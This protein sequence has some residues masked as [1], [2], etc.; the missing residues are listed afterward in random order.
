MC[1]KCGQLWHSGKCDAN[2]DSDFYGWAA[3]NGNVGNCPKCKAR[4][5]KISGCNHMTCGSC[6]YGWCW[7]C[8]KKYSSEHYSPINI[9]GCPGQQYFTY[10]RF[11]VILLN[12]GILI[13][14]PLALALT[15]PVALVVVFYEAS[16]SYNGCCSCCRHNC[17]LMCPA[18]LIFTPIVFAIGTIGSALALSLFLV[19]SMIF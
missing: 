13:L 14:L 16:F 12:L 6:N 3:S 7:L 1:F 19:P 4:I 17:F 15:P 11:W 18:I 8:G 10:N 9:F 5:E 2:V